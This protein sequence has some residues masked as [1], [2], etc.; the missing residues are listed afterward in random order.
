MFR[1]FKSSAAFATL[2]SFLC[3]SSCSSLIQHQYSDLDQL[4]IAANPKNS[5]YTSYDLTGA[6]WVEGQPLLVNK[7][8][9]FGMAMSLEGVG[10]AIAVGMRKNKN[11]E[12]A[13]KLST[14]P[15]LALNEKL[16]LTLGDIKN[17]HD[18]YQ[19]TVFAMLYGQPLANLQTFVELQPLSSLVEKNTFQRFVSV[20]DWVEL[21]GEQGWLANDGILISKNIDQSLQDITQM[22]E[23]YLDNKNINFENHEEIKYKIT[24]GESIKR[25]AG[26]IVSKNNDRVWVRDER[27]LNT[28][29]SYPLKLSKFD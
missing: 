27:L 16:Q 10:T 7:D 9:N 4:K 2:L 1:L 18:K 19:I 12:L 17:I 5:T 15:P 26:I 14:I 3:L 13:E 11:E 6:V 29:L 8:F 20:S 24:G 23:L 25:G 28:L 22:M 21:E